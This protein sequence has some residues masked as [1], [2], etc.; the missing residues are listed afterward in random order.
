MAVRF[1][2]VQSEFCIVI[3]DGILHILLIHCVCAAMLLFEF[4]SDV[5]IALLLI[6]G[7]SDDDYFTF[8]IYVV[9]HY[10]KS[11]C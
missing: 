6:E 3:S 4:K 9:G 10:M 5:R 2:L 1:D 11:I 7:T 8:V